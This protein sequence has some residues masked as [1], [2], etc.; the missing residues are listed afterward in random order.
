MLAGVWQKSH[1][2]FLAI[3]LLRVL[4]WSIF[5]CNYKSL[6]AFFLTVI[7]TYPLSAASLLSFLSIA[8]LN[9][10]IA[11]VVAFPNILLKQLLLFS[12]VEPNKT[13][14][15]SEVGIYK[16]WLSVHEDELS[17]SNSITEFSQPR[18]AV[19]LEQHWVFSLRA[20]AGRAELSYFFFLCDIQD[21]L[22]C[23]D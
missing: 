18:A 13:L 23:C 10:N 8:W 19:G 3:A 12:T 17:F 5:Q 14:F 11:S 6:S 2:S 1:R 4:K 16:L 22:V 7:V 21:R 9:T 15:P 20:V